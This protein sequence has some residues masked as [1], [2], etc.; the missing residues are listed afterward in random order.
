MLN[1]LLKWL[2]KTVSDVHNVVVGLIL[3]AFGTPIVIYANRIL[4]QTKK[5]LNQPLPLWVT[6]STGLGVL[7][8]CLIILKRALATPKTE[9]KKIQLE[10]KAIEMLRMIGA[11]ENPLDN[12]DTTIN[13]QFLADEL[14][15][16]PQTARHYL[17][18]LS[19]EDL[20]IFTFYG[21]L[22]GLS[23]EGREYLNKIGI[24]P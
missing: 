3:V 5:V 16:S 2:R 7:L 21:D 22:V 12:R 8:I 19:G 18:Q 23:S 11:M 14:R 6:V 20:I 15:L 24:M 1:I 4:N 13:Q 9:N 17:E 10:N